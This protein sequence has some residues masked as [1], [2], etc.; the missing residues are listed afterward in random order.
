[1]AIDLEDARAVVITSTSPGE[2]MVEGC[3]AATHEVRAHAAI[4]C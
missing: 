1:M 2:T 4:H 3:A